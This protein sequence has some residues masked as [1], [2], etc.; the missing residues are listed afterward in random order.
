[1]SNRSSSVQKSEQFKE[2]TIERQKILDWI[3]PSAVDYAD[4]QRA[5]RN[6]RQTGIG[7]WFLNSDKFRTWIHGDHAT[8]LCSGMPGV[9]KTMITSFVVSNVEE[10]YKNDAQVGVAYI[11]CQ[12]S[13]QEE[14]TAEYLKSSI[15]RQLLDRLNVIPD[16]IRSSYNSSRGKDDLTPDEVSDLLY[17][18]LGLF[19]KSVLIIDAID[20]LPVS[21]RD[22]FLPQILTLQRGFDMNIF[23]TSRHAKMTQKLLNGSWVEI[24]ARE[25]DLKCSA[26]VILKKGPLLRER[27]DLQQRAL[28]KILQVA[29]GILLLAVL[30]AQYLA[31]MQQMKQLSGAINGLKSVSDPYS[32]LYANAMQRLQEDH[33]TGDTKLGLTTICWLLLARRPLRL[34]ELLHALAIDERIPYLD[35]EN[36]PPVPH[37]VDACA[38]LIVANETNGTIELFHKTFHEYLVKD[39]SVWFPQGHDTIGIMCVR[40]LSFDAFADGPSK[41]LDTRSSHTGCQ[42]PD[43]AHFAYQSRLNQYPLYEYASKHWHDHI[44]GSNLQTAAIVMAFLADTN[45]V[46]ASCQRLGNLTPQTTGTHLAT[47]LLLEKSLKHH[48][49]LCRPRPDVKDNSGRSPLSYAAELN[50]LVAIDHLIRAGANPNLEDKDVN[51]RNMQNPVICTPLSFAA[52]KGHLLASKALLQ[53]RADVNYRD[54]Y[55]R[56]ALSYAAQGG[57]EAVAELLLQSG[58]HID[59]LDLVNRTPLF[60]AA[61]ADSA[62]VASLLLKRGANVNQADRCN[63]TPLLAAARAGSERMIALLIARGAK[64]NPESYENDTPLSRAVESQLIESVRLLLRSGAELSARTPYC[65]PLHLA[66]GMMSLYGGR[67]RPADEQM[68]GLL[69]AKGANPNAMIVWESWRGNPLDPP[70]LYALQNLPTEELSTTRMIKLLLKHGAKTD[71]VT[72]QGVSVR[73]CAKRHSKEVQDLLRQYGAR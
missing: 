9:G 48:L 19:K 10:R 46:S 16:R 59:P 30:Y 5:L 66:L 28:S 13:R 36:V 73:A 63:I 39:Q 7:E 15:L 32:V 45:K 34:T 23:A 49:K 3:C 53:R 1:M 41:K 2:Q 70:L 65:E 4:Q 68:L 33:E 54:K 52:G 62:G 29:D 14:Q 20:E 31:G 26:A 56:S 57:S 22:E 17:F 47:Q 18:I 11:Y 72:R 24:R 25:E 38:G 58:A 40:Y 67:R 21:T 71:Q 42:A 50:G 43:R 35:K 27:P 12:F 69:L 51:D 64:A 60:Y 8:L 37:V 55:G 44:R 6:R 61:A